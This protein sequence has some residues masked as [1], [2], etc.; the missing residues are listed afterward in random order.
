MLNYGIV[1][2]EQGHSITFWWATITFGGLLVVG[3][4]LYLLTHGGK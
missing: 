3:S 2:V 1:E 4:F